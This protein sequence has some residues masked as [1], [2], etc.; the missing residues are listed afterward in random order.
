MERNKLAL[1]FILIFTVLSTIIGLFNITIQSSAGKSSTKLS[2]SKKILKE[3]DAS[4]L[5]LKIEG[6]IHS[7]K[8]TYSSTGADTVLA[9]LREIEDRQDIKGILIEVNSPGGTVAASQEIYEELML[10]RKTKKI[11]VSM[12]DLAASGGYYIAAAADYIF[13]ESGTITG[14]IGVITMTPDISGLLDKYNVKMNVYKQGKYKDIL[15]M[16]KAP[17][18]EEEEI[19]QNMLKDTYTRFISDVSRGRNIPK[20]DVE[21]SAEGKIFSGEAA[22]KNHLVDAIGGRREA[23][24][25]L[26]ELAGS[27]GLL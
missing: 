16:Y 11:V 12:K 19:I 10:L 22:L 1:L 17:S 24:A 23:R 21:K 27:D 7:G 2:H 6:E 4:A 3:G 13:A 14:S 5:L 20:A 8:S 9:R 26:S 25:K 15:S 18:E